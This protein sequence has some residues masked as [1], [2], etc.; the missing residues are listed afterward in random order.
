MGEDILKLREPARL[1]NHDPLGRSL[2]H[3]KEGD[4]ICPALAGD[5]HLVGRRRGNFRLPAVDE[6]PD[7]TDDRF[8]ALAHCVRLRL[9]A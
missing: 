2:V 5:E 7:E 9:L 6:L 8:D 3:R 1:V 4:D